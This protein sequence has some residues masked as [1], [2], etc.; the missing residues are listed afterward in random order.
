MANLL[1]LKIKLNL[2]NSSL[3]F[4][5]GN[6]TE[7]QIREKIQALSTDMLGYLSSEQKSAII[8][9]MDFADIIKDKD[10]T[11]VGIDEGAA[12][13]DFI[14]GGV[15]SDKP[16]NKD[17]YAFVDTDAFTAEAGARETGDSDVEGLFAGFIQKYSEELDNNTNKWFLWKKDALAAMNAACAN[18][19]TLNVTLANI[20]G[21]RA[22]DPDDNNSETNMGYAYRQGLTVDDLTAFF[23]KAGVDVIFDDDEHSLYKKNNR[24]YQKIGNTLVYYNSTN[25]VLNTDVPSADARE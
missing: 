4:D 17:K 20:T 11:D 5:T 3:N 16:L 13:V 9:N 15:E 6:L 1:N 18:A 2:N 21:I 24:I 25:L 23:A 7:S 12:L 10:W 14:T 22:L 8:N 19:T